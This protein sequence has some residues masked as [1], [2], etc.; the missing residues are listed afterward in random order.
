M[1]NVSC[2]GDGEE[3]HLARNAAKAEEY[4]A[5]FASDGL[6]S[7]NVLGH[8]QV[9]SKK[10]LLCGAHVIIGKKYTQVSIDRLL[11]LADYSSVAPN[12]FPYVLHA[13]D[14]PLQVL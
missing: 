5:D 1:L 3:E 11:L 12:L 13:L 4:V 6:A 9:R 2:W 8:V 14:E 7:S 10:Q